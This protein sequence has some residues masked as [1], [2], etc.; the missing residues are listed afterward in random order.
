MFAYGFLFSYAEILED[1]LQDV[2]VGDLAGDGAEGGEGG[3]EVFGQEVGGGEEVDAAAHFG[4]G[5]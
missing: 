5:L 4:Q 3:A 1:V 2:G